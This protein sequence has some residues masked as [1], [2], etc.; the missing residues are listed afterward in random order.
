MKQITVVVRV[1]NRIDDLECCLKV[2][3]GLWK[4]NH[5]HIVLVS[6]GKKSGFTVPTA[7]ENLVDSH[8]CLEENAGHL[9]G[10]SQLL[11]AAIPCIP[12]ESDYTVILEADTWLLDDSLITKYCSKMEKEGS[13][14][15]SSEWI[16]NTWSV[17]LDFAIISSEYLRDNPS[18]VD[19]GEH[20]EKTVCNYLM[21]DKQHILF[22]NENMPVHPSK[23][24]RTLYPKCNYRFNTFVTSK[25]VTHHVEE[26]DFS[27]EEKKHYANLCLEEDFFTVSLVQNRQ[28][29]RLKHRLIALLVRVL[30][31][32][33]WFKRKR[34]WQG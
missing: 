11:R 16:S 8:I 22:I 13:V 30:P 2:I 26:L 32:S 7:L 9:K 24:F 19:Y 21:D 18:L 15:S 20:P 25:M 31:Q 17:G 23:T 27:L 34:R 1:F 29:F 10:N 14:W 28:L 6:N 12:I 4:Q 5:Y 33:S 3:K